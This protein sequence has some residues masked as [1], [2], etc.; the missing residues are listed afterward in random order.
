MRDFNGRPC[1]AVQSGHQEPRPGAGK[2]VHDLPLYRLHR[3]YGAGT[4]VLLA[5][6]GSD[7]AKEK[8]ARC[9][10]IL[11]RKSVKGTLR[12][13]P[14]SFPDPAR[15]SVGITCHG[16]AFAQRPGLFESILQQR[17]HALVLT[18]LI[19]NALHKVR[20]IKHKSNLLRWLNDGAL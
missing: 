16:V 20:R 11:G 4:R 7:E 9:L 3:H 19:K 18:S 2:P 6:S 15:A 14:N 5:L 17:Q 13:Y 8:L 10:L 12:R 1:R